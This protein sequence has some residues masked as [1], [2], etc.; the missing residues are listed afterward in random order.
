MRSAGGRL[1]V[2]LEA[3]AGQLQLAGRRARALGYNGG[4]PGPTLRVQPGDVLSVRLSNSLDQPTN[5][6]VHGLHVSP[7]GAGDN[8]FVVVNPGAAFDYEYRIPADHPPGQ[9][10]PGAPWPGAGGPGQGRSRARQ[11]LDERFAKG[12]LT[13]DQYREQVRVLGE[14][15]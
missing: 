1:E 14:E 11:I 5:L 10:G 15:P 4:T 8:V 2:R 9:P 3:R 13:A 7:E 6:H 12:E